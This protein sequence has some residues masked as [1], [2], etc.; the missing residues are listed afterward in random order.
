MRAVLTVD[1]EAWWDAA[2]AGGGTRPGADTL[3]AEVDDVVAL[4][5]AAGHRATFFVLGARAAAHP[6]LIG[7]LAACGHEVACHGWLHHRFDQLSPADLAADLVRARHL[8]QDLSGQAVT[9]VRAP[10]W[11]LT[12]RRPELVEVLGEAGFEVDSSIFPVRTPLYG[13]DRVPTGPFWLSTGGTRLLEVPPAVASLGRIRLPAGGGI[14]WRVLPGP[15]RAA[16][17]ARAP[18]PLVVYWHPWELQAVDPAT[19]TVPWA[20]RL[21]LT[22]GRRRLRA[23]LPAWL[24]SLETTTLAKFRAQL[25]PDALPRVVWDYTGPSSA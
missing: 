14:W 4:L 12:A 18:H 15:V 19:S 25:N 20:A 13:D 23:W 2:L 8:L 10:T 1:V 11:S 9:A 17:M 3:E 22:V 16:L 7:R 6:R 5:A 21:S 24:A